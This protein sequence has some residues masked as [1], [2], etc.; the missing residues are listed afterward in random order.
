MG[1]PWD[2]RKNISR[3]NNYDDLGLKFTRMEVS[4]Y[5]PRLGRFISIDPIAENYAY[6]STYAF[7]VKI[8]WAWE[9]N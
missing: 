2:R 5:D 9:A 7:A 1:I 8:N 6:N 3:S 4:F